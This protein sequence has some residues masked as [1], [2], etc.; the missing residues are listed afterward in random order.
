MADEEIK[1]EDFFGRIIQIGD[2]V[3]AASGHALQCYKVVKL[4]PKM[5]RVVK[6]NPKTSK[7]KKGMLRYSKEL[8]VVDGKMATFYLMKNL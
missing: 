6:F 3:I 8:L 5:V 2:I 7:S 1:H 4:T